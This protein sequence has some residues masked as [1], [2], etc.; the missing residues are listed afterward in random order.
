VTR[1]AL[2]YRL[3]VRTPVLFPRTFS[4]RGETG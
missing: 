1:P 4:P 2:L 3:K